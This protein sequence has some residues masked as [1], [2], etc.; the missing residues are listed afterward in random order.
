[1]RPCDP[2]K[3]QPACF[4]MLQLQ[5]PPFVTVRKSPMKYLVIFDLDGT[6]A[7]SK[8]SLDAEMARLLGWLLGI[9]KLV[10]ISGGSWAQFEQQVLAFLPHDKRL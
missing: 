4:S 5:Q 8:L 10:I 3:R 1:M 7:E 6:L 2:P 9:V